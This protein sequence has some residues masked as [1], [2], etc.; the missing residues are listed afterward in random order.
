MLETDVFLLLKVIAG[1]EDRGFSERVGFHRSPDTAAA[2]RNLL[3]DQYSIEAREAEATNLGRKVG[4][5][6]TELEV[7]G[8]MNERGLR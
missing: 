8:G 6:K 3:S 1:D 7:E 5:H 2:V 4:V